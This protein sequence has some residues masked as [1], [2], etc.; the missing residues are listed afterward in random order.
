M[1]KIMWENIFKSS[2]KEIGSILSENFL[3]KDLSTKELKFIS[4]IVHLRNYRQNEYVFHKDELGVGMYIIVHGAINIIGENGTEFSHDHEKS[5][6][7]KLGPG[8]FF[9]ELSLIE[10]DGRRTATALARE[11]TAL[12]GFFKPNLLEILE[13]SP[14]AGVKITMRLSEVLGKRLRKTNG[15]LTRL[16]NQ[17]YHLRQEN[18]S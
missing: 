9:G 10:K 14:R 11:D 4:K 8:D 6:L 7:T 2:T 15:K 5:I 17:L 12:I 16:E 1:G 18:I 13:R 3:F